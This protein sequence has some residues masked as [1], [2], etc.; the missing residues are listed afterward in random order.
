MEVVANHISVRGDG[1]ENH[2]SS[3]SSNFWK[4]F[5]L[6]LKKLT[7]S[8]SNEAGNDKSVKYKTFEQMG[9]DILDKAIS[10]ISSYYG[11]SQ[12]LLLDFIDKLKV[13]PQKT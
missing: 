2:L 10:L 9:T 3:S 7:K 5:E 4:V 8:E 12:E 1:K 13:K 6:E 11:G